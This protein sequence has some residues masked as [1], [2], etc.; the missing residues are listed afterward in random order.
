MSLRPKIAT[1]SL[2]LIAL[3]PLFYAFSFQ[4]QQKNIR[5]RMKEELEEKMLHTLTLDQAQLHWTRPGK[6]IVINDK[7]FDVKTVEMNEDGSVVITGLFDEEETSLVKQIK[8][9]QQEN[10]GEKLLGQFFQLQ[11]NLP[12]EIT[13][14]TINSVD[15]NPQQ[16]PR[17]AS[18]LSVAWS[19]I[20][21]P[22][23]QL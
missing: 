7:L 9:N 15:I 23:P 3:A 12:S 17:F 8:K 10:G 2:L 19:G 13:S 11:L 20:L 18:A 14:I 6:E 4:W 21:T 16:F 1:I 5:H 22:P